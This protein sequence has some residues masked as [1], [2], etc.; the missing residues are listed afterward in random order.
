MKIVER[1]K[2]T[3]LHVCEITDLPF[4]VTLVKVRERS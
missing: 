3:V 4:L 1:M 2:T